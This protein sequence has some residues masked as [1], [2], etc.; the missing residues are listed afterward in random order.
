MSACCEIRDPRGWIL[1]CFWKHSNVESNP[2]SEFLEHTKVL[3]GRCPNSANNVKES[4]DVKSRFDPIAV[5]SEIPK[6]RGSVLTADSFSRLAILLAAAHVLFLLAEDDGNGRVSARKMHGS[7]QDTS[8]WIKATSKRL[9]V[10]IIEHAPRQIDK[11][12]TRGTRTEES[13]C[14]VTRTPRLR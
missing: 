9:Q 1:K 8:N 6:R 11:I 5:R 2:Y 3:C 14:K 7:R 13:Q 4:P 12:C 10:Q